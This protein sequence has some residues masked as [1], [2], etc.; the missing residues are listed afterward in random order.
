MIIPEIYL[1]LPEKRGEFFADDDFVSIDFW[2]YSFNPFDVVSII[3]S[4]NSTK[5]KY[6]KDNK[7]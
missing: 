6:E 4:F 1:F 3:D 7:I 2:K 5:R